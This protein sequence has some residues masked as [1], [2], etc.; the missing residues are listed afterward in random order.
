MNVSTTAESWLYSGP[1]KRSEII[2]GRRA[3]F[4]LSLFFELK[5]FGSMNFLPTNCKLTLA[6]IR[7]Y[8]FDQIQGADK[9]GYEDD[10][11]KVVNFKWRAG[12]L[13]EAVTHYHHPVRES[14]VA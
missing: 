1:P 12:L 14:A 2:L 10:C 8:H 11:G 6:G 13:Y 5:W 3:I 4:I 7:D 9:R